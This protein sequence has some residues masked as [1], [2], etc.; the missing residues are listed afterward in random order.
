M[1]GWYLPMCLYA[2]LTNHTLWE[3]TF[4]PAVAKYTQ[5]PRSRRQL[6]RRSFSATCITTGW[7]KWPSTVWLT[8]QNWRPRQPS[9]GYRTGR[10]CRPHSGKYIYL[11]AAIPFGANFKARSNFVCVS[12]KY[13]SIK[14]CGNRPPCCIIATTLQALICCRS[15][16]SPPKKRKSIPTNL[17]ITRAQHPAQAQ[18]LLDSLQEVRMEGRPL[19]ARFQRGVTDPYDGFVGKL[20]RCHH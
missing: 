2:A 6:T 10:V 16:F 9:S 17:R 12:N 3:P 14:L 18:A 5:R 4:D 11:C 19:F 7:R 8:W 20:V 1:V 15:L 13:C